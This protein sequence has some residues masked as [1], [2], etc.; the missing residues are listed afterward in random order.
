MPRTSRTF[1]VFVSSTFSDLKAERNALH[2]RVFPRLRE[3]CQAHGCRFQAIDLRWGVSEE[4]ALDQQT[5][6]ICLGEIERCQKTSPRPNFIVLLGNRYGWRPLPGQIPAG[7][8]G[9]I[10]AKVPEEERQ[11][12][13]DWYRRDDNASPEGAFVLQPRLGQVEVFEVWEPLERRLHAT[14]LKAARELAQWPDELL[15]YTASATEQEILAGALRVADA[16]DHVFC[17]FREIEDLPQDDAAAGFI[18]LD[19][20][21]KADGD[22]ARMLAELKSRLR[23]YLPDSTRAYTSR[24]NG[25]GPTLDHLDQLCEDLV[26]D[27]EKVLLE[28]LGLLDEVQPLQREIEAHEAFGRDRARRF[29][30]RLEILHSIAEHLRAGGSQ[31]LTVWG[32][33]GCGKSALMARAIEEA[34]EAYP[35]AVVMSRFIGAT[36]ESSSGRALLHSLCQ[37]IG[38]AYGGDESTIPSDFKGLLAEFPKRL[39][40]ATSER[41][42]LLFLDALDQ[43][44]DADRAR[45][46]VWLPLELPTNVRLVTSTTPGE[47]LAALEGRLAAEKRL[48]IKPMSLEEGGAILNEWLAEA[49]RDLQ[50]AQ[51]EMVLNRFRGCSLPLY[52]KLAFE[53]ARRWRSYDPL[54][55]FAVDVPGM[56]RQLFQRL[57]AEAAHGGMLVSRSLGY[58]AAARNGLSEDELI[59]VLSRDQEVIA[60]F[61]R[62]S[63]KSPEVDRLPVVVWSRLYFDLEPYLAERAADGTSLLG[64]Y[65]RQLGEV[66]ALEHLMGEAKLARHRGLAEYFD[67]APLQLETDGQRTPNLRKLSEQVFQQT[68]AGMREAASSTLLDFGFLESKIARYDVAERRDPSGRIIPEYNGVYHLLEDFDLTLNMLVGE[69]ANT[70]QL[71]AAISEATRKEAHVLS[72]NPELVWQQLFNRLQWW[73]EAGM[74]FLERSSQNRLPAKP[75]FRLLMPVEESRDL[76]F[77]LTGHR[78]PIE[79][80]AISPDG[81][82]VASASQDMTLRLWHLEEGRE[83][84]TLT[85]HR[86]TVTGCD[87]H[88]RG[89]LLLSSS[90]DKTTRVWDVRSGKEVLNPVGHAG[91]VLRSQFS[92][93]G[94][95]IVSLSDDQQLRIWETETG[96]HVYAL[97]GCSTRL[98]LIFHPDGRGLLGCFQETHLQVVDLSTGDVAGL[99]ITP[100]GPVTALALSPQ[101]DWFVVGEKSG[102]LHLYSFRKSEPLASLRGHA[103]AVRCCAISAQGNLVL[104]GDRNGKLNLWEKDS[105]MPR[106]DIQAFAGPVTHCAFSPDGSLML[107][108]SGVP[109]HS[110]GN[111]FR[112]RFWETT[113]GQE[114]ANLEGHTNA[115]TTCAFTP[116][117]R[118][119]VSAGYDHA[120]RIWQTPQGDRPAS[121]RP[122][123]GVVSTCAF[124]PDGSL[125]ATIGKDR[126]IIWDTVK[127][128]RLNQVPLSAEDRIWTCRFGPGGKDLVL[129]GRWV[130]RFSLENSTLSKIHESLAF[131]GISTGDSLAISADAS[132]YAVGT[133]GGFDMSRSQ[134]RE[135]HAIR[136]SR[137]SSGETIAKLEGHSGAI[138]CIAFH[139]G[140]QS[141]ISG[142]SDTTVKGW[143]LG[144]GGLFHKSR[145]T[146]TFTGHREQV[147]ACAF[148][149]DALLVTSGDARGGLI[150]WEAGS[151][152]VLQ[153]CEAHAAL[154]A[155]LV[156]SR[157]GRYLLSAGL[158]QWVKVWEIP[159]MRLIASLP[160]VGR[161]FPH[162]DSP[163]GCLGCVGEES[164]NVYLFKL[165]G[166]EEN[167]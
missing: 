45:N 145:N 138:N 10:I 33:S 73:G 162:L 156:F 79:A 13:R 143:L 87:F 46:L 49:G 23:G 6:N 152:K 103:G 74:N 118:R 54:P 70:F 140:G 132:L 101:G 115:I 55:E 37:E 62:R 12:V 90:R 20:D 35:Q 113:R 24:W 163:A 71:L 91:R 76:L 125:F 50:P 111:D 36:P 14:L 48:E 127:A 155:S 3:L 1:R 157:D 114:V 122:H 123:H 65:H 104:S 80:V 112:I 88:P 159:A 99:P 83:I 42:L 81:Q 72:R 66:A 27:L 43:L 94:A 56:I 4:A 17:Y 147:T 130:E 57:S 11:L 64:F 102:G 105:G 134:T 100:G 16:A 161:D 32:E 22:A 25:D 89:N 133:T 106:A 144:S 2:E 120:L 129:C 41:P 39:A 149:P 84:V 160:T 141:L 154:V 8:F 28:E 158:D 146:F 139:P 51:R 97:E 108:V 7:E 98:P 121:R 21:G 92:P 69:P 136:V 47:C 58:L 126:L 116:E 31:P 167:S 75:W 63:P 164:G 110:G 131:S 53:E 137:V 153:S 150:L 15:K 38:R 18:D 44:S 86:D 77:T 40:L 59:D 68:R 5:M 107:A 96:K 82:V 30:G 61:L 165:S 29:I 78:N 119:I 95:Y 52:L 151:R 9:Q 60:D 142:S 93:D 26:R 128:D 166:L 135:I 34:K 67:M 148:H 124:S 117:S 109:A 19:G 85:G